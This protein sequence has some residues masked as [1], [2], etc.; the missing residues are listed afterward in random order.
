MELNG[1]EWKLRDMISKEKDLEKRERWEK[2][3]NSKYNR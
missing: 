1:E 2:I 3:E